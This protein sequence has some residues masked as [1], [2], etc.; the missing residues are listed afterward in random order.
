MRFASEP[1]MRLLGTDGPNLIRELGDMAR[2]LY[3]S[4]AGLPPSLSSG[5][6]TL[7]RPHW[8]H[9]IQVSLELVGEPGLP[10]DVL[11]VLVAVPRR[12]PRSPGKPSVMSAALV[13]RLLISRGLSDR[14]RQV[15]LLLWSG[16]TS[17]EIAE[18]LQVT[19]HTARR[20]TERV[21]RKLRVRSRA[22][23]G[24][25][26]TEAAAIASDPR[27][28]AASCGLT[29]HLFAGSGALNG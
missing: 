9:T 24:R 10:T 8:H 20:H 11:C 4:A 26:I 7:A 15:A 27:E 21:F 22:A 3:Q 14:E 18:S 5:E 25:A 13:D 29:V 12:A 6:Q 23:V 16:A 17:A 1:A 28:E 19:V 2:A